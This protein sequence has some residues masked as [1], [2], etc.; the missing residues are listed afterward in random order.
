MANLNE[1]ATWEPGIF[2]IETTTPALGGPEGPV[3]TAPRQLAN[4][5]QYLK[6]QTDAINAT[7]NAAKGSATSID[8]RISAVER[9]TA[10]GDFNFGSTGGATVTHGIGN[11]NYS[12]Y[13]TAN[14]QTGGDLGDVYVN[15][16]KNSFTVYN[17]GGF[18]GSGRYQITH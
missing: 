1:T 8:A 2:Q 10:M 17:S 3:N 14:V 18:T 16:A 7:L 6:A 5:T 4:R 15:K 13:V 12:V 9:T 11:T